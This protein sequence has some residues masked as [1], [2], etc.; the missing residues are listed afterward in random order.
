MLGKNPIRGPEKGDG[1][2]LDVQHI[3]PTL[4]GEG[5]YAGVPAIF[6]RLGGCNLAC[7]FCDTEFESFRNMKLEEILERVL[8]FTGD[9]RAFKLI[10]I[11]GGEPL[12]QP[13]GPLCA[14]LVKAGFKVQ[15]ETNGTLWRDLP[16]AVEIVCSPKNT[17]NGY[18]PLRPDLRPRVNAFKFIISASRPE[19]AFVGDAGQG[20]TPVFLQPMDEYDDAKNAANMK[21]AAELA[22]RHGYRLSLQLH[23]ILGIE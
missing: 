17:G 18:F 12:R 13:I 5:P 6:I 14:A 2:T 1:G 23:K 8:S 15:I 10:V 7:A 16:E 22:Q 3:F 4:Q 20:D 21:L 9:R 19:Y 11:T